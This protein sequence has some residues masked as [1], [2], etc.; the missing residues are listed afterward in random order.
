MLR[1][2]QDV[3]GREKRFSVRLQVETD[4]FSIGPRWKEIESGRVRDKKGKLVSWFLYVFKGSV[5]YDRLYFMSMYDASF[6]DQIPSNKT[7]TL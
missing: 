3:E 4:P 5:P 7:I 2:A 1:M 6:C